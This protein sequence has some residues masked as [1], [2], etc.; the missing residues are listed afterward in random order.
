M[1]TEAIADDQ[2]E[3][4]ACWCCGE[5]FDEHD[6]SR[7]GSHPEVG[8]CAGCAQWLYRR[9]RAS[10]EAGTRTPGSSVRR[11]IAAARPRVIRAGLQDWPVL[12]ALLRRLDKHLP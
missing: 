1:A 4:P 10:A 8:V 12:G 9:A 5:A 2:L 6:L 3:R 11:G 7:L